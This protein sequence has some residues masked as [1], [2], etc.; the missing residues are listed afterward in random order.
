MNLH[1]IPPF[2]KSC[3]GSGDSDSRASEPRA[4]VSRSADGSIVVRIEAPAVGAP[5][6]IVPLNK[7]GLEEKAWKALVQSGELRARKLGRRWYTT[8]SAL[9]AL[10]LDAPAPKKRAA[11]PD[12]RALVATA[13][14]ER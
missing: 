14:G 5:D 4:E 9:C 3:E 12:Y 1:Q 13:M 11:A 2:G 10:V 6:E 8:R 7:S